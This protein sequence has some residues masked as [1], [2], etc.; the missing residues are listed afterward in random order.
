MRNK[1]FID[2]LHSCIVWNACVRVIDRDLF[3]GNFRTSGGLSYTCLLYTSTLPIIPYAG[4]VSSVTAAIVNTC[5]LAG[6]IAAAL[7]LDHVN[8]KVEVP[9]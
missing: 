8:N 2:R 3:R 1:R 9:E 5:C 4:F 6:G 7:L